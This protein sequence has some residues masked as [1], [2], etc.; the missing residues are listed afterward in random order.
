MNTEWTKPTK[1][2]AGVGLMLVGIYILYLS[3]PV[4]PLLV[5]AALIAV[6]VRPAILGLHHRLHLPR[7]V[8]VA[9]VYL[10][11]VVL[12]P[13][14][15]LL[16]VPVIVDA[17][18][19]IAGLD[20]SAILQ[21]IVAWLSSVLTTIQNIQLPPALDAYVDPTID[22][23]LAE[24]QLDASAQVL[25]PPSVVTILRSLGVAL[26]STFDVA[27]GLVSVVFSQIALMIFMF[28]S[29]IYISLGAHTY[30][31]AFLRLVPPLYQ[32][33]IAILLAR[34]ERIWN[35]FFRGELTLMVVI[36]MITWLGLTALGMPGAL[37]LAVIAG[38]LELIPNLGPVIATIPAVFVALL[39]GSTFL[40]LSNLAFVGVVILFYILVQQLE[41][42][43][44]VPRV[45]GDA[46]ELPP[47]IVMT[48]VVVGATVGGILGALLATPVVATIRELLRYV[49]LKMQGEQP[50]PPDEGTREPVIPFMTSLRNWLQRLAPTGRPAPQQPDH[51]SPL[52]HDSQPIE[53]D[54]RD[55][56]KETL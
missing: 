51:T 40:P 1:Y 45:L 30:R 20:Y 48:G 4:I 28:L 21:A 49:Y 41:N 42:S 15:V 36:G 46:V 44:I 27:T 52:S 37:S 54:S 10:G 23:L 18:G 17:L 3:R 26:L 56:S 6:I 39:Q 9:L 19:Y 12:F 38:L 32:S 11:V 25:E 24:L 43:V 2:I 14:A 13:V 47:L 31:G 5:V 16:A 22:S 53:E 29:S 50:F 8:A 7:G 34:I 55:S 33:E 35:N